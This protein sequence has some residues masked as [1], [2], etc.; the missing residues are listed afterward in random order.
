MRSALAVLT[1]ASA[2]GCALTGGVFFAFSS[3]VMRAL[4]RLPA[5]QGLAAMQSIN[6]VVINPAFML[7][8]LGSGAA[9]VLSS[10]LILSGMAPA[11]G[12]AGLLRHAASLSYVVGSIGVTMAFN[13]PRNELL[14]RLSP[15]VASAEGLW[16]RYLVEWT[17]Y[18]HV[19]TAASLLAAILLMASLA[20]RDGAPP[21][22][23]P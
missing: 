17:A 13:V 2:L 4:G 9:C 8:F 7:A 15:A 6:V 14:A 3:F 5:A 16:A 18:N 23:G 22:G 20:L 19:R 11:S 21:V 1:L 10:L 12:L